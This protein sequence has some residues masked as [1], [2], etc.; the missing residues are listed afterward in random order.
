MLAVKLI[1]TGE[2]VAERAEGEGEEGNGVNI[3]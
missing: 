2:S 1:Q 3:E